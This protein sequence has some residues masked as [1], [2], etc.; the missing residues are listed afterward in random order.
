MPAGR[1]AATQRHPEADGDAAAPVLEQVNEAARILQLAMRSEDVAAGLVPP[2]VRRSLLAHELA[3][4]VSFAAIDNAEAAT[5]AAVA[6]R[7]ADD[8]V[9]FLRLL[10]VD[11][12]RQA[13]GPAVVRRLFA[14]EAGGI[15]S[16][17]GAAELL[18]AT[19]ADLLVVLERHAE[20]AAGRVLAEAEGQGVAGVPADVGALD[21]AALEQLDQ[22]AHRLA[23]A[24]QVD[25]VRFLR[26][27]AVRA[28]TPASGADLVAHLESFAAGLS[29]AP[30]E[31][32]GTQAAAGADGLGRQAGAGVVPVVPAQVYASE[33]LD[34]ST[35]G[36]CSL[37]DGHEYAT[38][39]EGQLDYPTGTYRLC[40]GGLRCRGTLVYVWPS[41]APATLEVPGDRP[42][43]GAGGPGGPPLPA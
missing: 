18:D 22:V 15:V 11:L 31:Q 3:A 23:Q 37:I 27:E 36:P 40:E 7:L 42:L 29:P 8:R 16:V 41:E 2:W 26:E 21:A 6:R 32:L 20:G 17:P 34:S 43:L 30:L 28:A 19:A 12:G 10:L 39:L 9:A 38:A 33:L 24:P 5:G 14:I 1:R 35:C 4:G 25:L 13:D